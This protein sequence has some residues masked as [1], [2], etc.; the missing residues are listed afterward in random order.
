MSAPPP[1]VKSSDG[2]VSILVN[3]AGIAGSNA[4]R[5]AGASRVAQTAPDPHADAATPGISFKAPIDF[6]TG[7]VFSTAASL[8]QVRGVIGA[9]RAKQL[10]AAGYAC[11]GVSMLLFIIVGYRS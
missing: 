6:A 7:A 10:N 8:L 2:P 3:S 4:S 1:L 11:M 9:L 5:W